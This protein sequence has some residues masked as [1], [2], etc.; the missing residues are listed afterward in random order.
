MSDT[1]KKALI[2]L[3]NKNSGLMDAFL[4]MLKD[5][6]LFE[7]EKYMYFYRFVE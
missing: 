6:E 3:V 2:E 5:I 7:D 1:V 4:G